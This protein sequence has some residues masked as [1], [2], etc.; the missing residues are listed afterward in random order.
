MEHTSFVGFV[1]V[2]KRKTSV[3]LAEPNRGGEVR[4]LGE[5]PSTLTERPL[6]WILLDNGAGG[7]CTAPAG[8]KA[9]GSEPGANFADH[10]LRL[11]P[12]R[13]KRAAAFNRIAEDLGPGASHEV[14]AVRIV[15]ASSR[16]RVE[17]EGLAKFVR[18]AA[19]GANSVVHCGSEHLQFLEISPGN[20]LA[21]LV[22]DP[23]PLAVEGRV[24]E[25]HTRV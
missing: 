12:G 6:R 2:H 22:T 23:A 13:L 17:R 7:H 14:T 4:F 5:I 1:D 19:R 3:A 18:L 10:A 9:E 16:G 15:V 24:P 8:S 21:V 25:C 11:L 20:E